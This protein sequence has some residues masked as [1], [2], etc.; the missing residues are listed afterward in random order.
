MRAG[1]CVFVDCMCHFLTFSKLFMFTQHF[2][3]SERD[4]CLL[5]MVFTARHDSLRTGAVHRPF[6][7]DIYKPFYYVYFCF[8]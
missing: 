2:S 7:F 1:G 5:V 8:L 3:E 4:L 6:V